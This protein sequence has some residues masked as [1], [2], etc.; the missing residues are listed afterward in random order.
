MTRFRRAFE[1]LLETIVLALMGLLALVV[2]SGV[3]FR[4]VGA[5]LV[6]YD[7]VASILLAWLT[8]YGACL[9]ALRRAHIGYPALVESVSS[10]L[11]WPLIVI[12]ELVVI[13][14]VTLVAWTGWQVVAV[15]DGFYLTSLPWMSRQITQSVIPVSAVLFIVAELLSVAELVSVAE[16]RRGAAP[17]AVGEEVS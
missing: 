2:V 16:L 7:E 14:F 8:Y 13:G 10:G 15:L 3:L 9:A 5:P 6:W 4:K 11:R 12:R 17:A 1:Q